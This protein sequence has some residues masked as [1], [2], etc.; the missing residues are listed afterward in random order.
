MSER[1]PLAEIPST[2]SDESRKAYPSATITGMATEP[3]TKAAAV[4]VTHVKTLEAELKA[5]REEV[6]RGLLESIRK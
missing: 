2:F 5:A 3:A 6:R 1:V 4:D